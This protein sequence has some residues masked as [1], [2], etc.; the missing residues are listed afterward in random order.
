MT[1]TVDLGLRL[2]LRRTALQI[3]Q[4]EL[5]AQVGMNPRTLSALE[6]GRR[7]LD[8]LRSATLLRLATCLGVSTDYL[9]GRCMQEGDEHA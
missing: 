2:K 8:R 6:R 5:A 7:P 4:Q 3:P 9:L 1:G